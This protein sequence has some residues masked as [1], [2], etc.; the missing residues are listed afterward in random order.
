MEIARAAAGVAC[1]KEHQRIYAEWFA[2]A[3]PDKELLP[4]LVPRP[5][6]KIR[7]V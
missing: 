5:P 4:L 2:V 6:P 3:D 1:S 7:E